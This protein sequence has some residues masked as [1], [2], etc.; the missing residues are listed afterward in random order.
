MRLAEDPAFFDL[1]IL[2][3]RRLVGERPLFLPPSGTGDARWLYRDAPAC[4]LAH[5]TDPDPLFIYANQTAQKLFEYSWDEF[6]ALPSR[7]S[8]ETPDRAERQRLLDAVA[9]DGFATGYTGVRI[10]K[11]GRRFLI[12]DGVLWQLHGQDG[13]LHGVAATFAKWRDV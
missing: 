13:T 4:V 5:S 9:L 11:S 12:E 1:L 2:S 7:L 6:V 8:A 10:A 3:Y